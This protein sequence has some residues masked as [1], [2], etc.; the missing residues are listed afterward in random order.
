MGNRFVFG[1]LLSILLSGCFGRRIVDW[2]VQTF[3]RDV[4]GNCLT[5]ARLFYNIDPDP[6][7][8]MLGRRTEM[9]VLMS[10]KIGYLNGIAKEEHG[11]AQAKPAHGPYN[12][13]FA[14]PGYVPVYFR[15]QGL[16][17]MLKTNVFSSIVRD[18]GTGNSFFGVITVGKMKCK[19][20][21]VPV[22]ISLDCPQNEGQRR[23]EAILDIMGKDNPFVEIEGCDQSYMTVLTIDDRLLQSAIDLFDIDG[24]SLH[25][26]GAHDNWFGS[27][28][29]GSEVYKFLSWNDDLPKSFDKKYNEDV[30]CKAQYR[31]VFKND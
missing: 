21:L 27:G 17:I 1:I 20:P 19:V 22:M 11:H 9:R 4:D 8:S 28:I 25:Y 6:R 15:G 30:K 12:A 23:R 31:R 10:N 16:V 24:E 7:V 13:F 2:N 14:A 29:K 18:V 5:D 3:V 26:G